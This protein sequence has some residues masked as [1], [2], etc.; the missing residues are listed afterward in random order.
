M[1]KKTALFLKTKHIGDSIILTSAIAALPQDYEAVDI[2]CLEDSKAIFEMN[3][4]VRNIFVIPRHLKGIEKWAA[5]LK[6]LNNMSKYRY[7]FLAQFSSDWRG[8]I[9]SRFLKVKLSV[10]RKN[11]RNNF[12]WHKSFDLIANIAINFR[13]MAEQDVDLLRKAG[14]YNEAEAPPYQLEVSKY[15]IIEIKGWL[16]RNKILDQKKIVIIHAPSR[17]KFKEVP[18]LTWVN[19]IQ[20]IKIKGYQI[21]LSGSKGDYEFNKSIFDLCKIKPILTDNFSLEDTA[22]LYKLADLIISI[23][24]M[25]VHLAGAI[26]TPVVAVFGPT[27]EKNWAPWK[28]K[29]KIVSLSGEDS[30]SLTCRPCG[31]DGCGGSKVSH[32]LTLIPSKMITSAAF[33][34][35]KD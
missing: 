34:L 30:E 5:Y 21:V 33:E 19:V 31:L 4:R 11:F 25:S 8:A 27:N 22:A 24:S 10:A 9:L 20:D 14:L 23:D 13:H 6:V 35:L 17:W 12:L 28:V 1:K 3:P 15:K 18:D 7:N 16:K 32:C 2:L 26:K 29:H